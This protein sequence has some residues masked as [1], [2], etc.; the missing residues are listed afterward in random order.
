M[1]RLPSP[2]ET[3]PRPQRKPSGA[4]FPS[5]W[6]NSKAGAIGAHTA[7]GKGLQRPLSLR[8]VA[9]TIA[10]NRKQRTPSRKRK[11]SQPEKNP[12]FFGFEVTLYI[13]P[14]KVREPY[15]SSVEAPLS[16]G[17]TATATAEAL[18]RLFPFS[19]GQQQGRSHRSG[20]SQREK[21]AAASI[22]PE[23]SLNDSQE[24]EAAHTFKEEK[25]PTAR[26]NP[27]FFQI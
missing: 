16:I 11:S 12:S 6:D 9:S 24:P 23:G 2:S 10:R 19:M 14:Y 5:R 22:L 13:F 4:S 27:L 25:I 15:P 18:W 7:N 26:K 17:D 1:L 21:P 20:H 3:R 8:R